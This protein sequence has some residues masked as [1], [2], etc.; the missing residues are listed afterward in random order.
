MS[1]G[2]IRISLVIIMVKI[3]R[4][5]CLSSVSLFRKQLMDY[6]HRQRF[7]KF[8]I[9]VILRSHRCFCTVPILKRKQMR[10]Q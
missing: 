7:K 3:R 4:I 8:K 10:S 5:F 2:L 6:V 1:C 9:E